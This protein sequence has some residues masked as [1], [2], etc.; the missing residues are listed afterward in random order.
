M[1]REISLLLIFAL[2]LPACTTQ[3]STQEQPA[4]MEQTSLPANLQPALVLNAQAQLGE[5][6]LWHQKE[7]LLYWVDIEGKEL[8]L[9]DPATGQDREIPVGARIGTVVPTQDGQ[10]LVALQ[11]GIHLLHLDS[12]KLTLVDNPLRGTPSLRFNDGKVDPAGRFWVGSM[13]LDGKKNAA[14]LYRLNHD[15]T[16]QQ[17]LDDISISNGIVWSA[18][19]KT[20]YYIDTPTRTIKAYDYDDATGDLSNPRVVVEVPEEAGFPDG[21]SIDAEGKLWVAHYG[22]HSV[23]RWDPNNGRM[24]QKVELP[25]PNV[26]SCAFGGENLDVLYITTAREGLSEEQLREYPLS[27]GLFRV[28]PGVRG[29]PTNFYRGTLPGEQ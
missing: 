12:E 17:V 19:R 27:G 8:H 7:Q 6:A 13:H 20:M 29:V 26:T 9:Y 21:M 28:S 15:G 25:A 23:I 18:N 14:A 16:V 1:T 4:M 22:G 10:A 24:M 3:S 11:N 2:A 5:G